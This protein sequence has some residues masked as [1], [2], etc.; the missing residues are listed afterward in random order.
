MAIL[1]AFTRTFLNETGASMHL[2]LRDGDTVR[3]LNNGFGILFPK[4]DF[5][6]DTFVGKCKG[7]VQPWVFP[8]KEGGWGIAA[9]RQDFEQS[10]AVPEQGKGHCFLLFRTDNF[11]EYEEIGL[12]PLAPEGETITDLRCINVDDGY[13]FYAQFGGEWHAYKTADLHAFTPV[14]MKSYMAPNRQPLA[15]CD[16]A[17]ACVLP[18]SD[19]MAQALR[20]R[21]TPPAL[22]ESAPR[23][24]YPLMPER[25]DPMAIRW[26][27]GYLFAATDDECGQRRLLLR[28][29][30]T[31]H[32][33]PAAKDHPIFHSPDSGDYSGC[34]WAPELHMVGGKLC[35]FFA[36]GMPHWYTVQSRVIWLEGDDPLNPAC[37]SAPRRVETP[38]GDWLTHTGI[39]LDMTVIPAK[40]G[41]HVVWS[42]RVIETENGLRCGSADLYIAKLDS[43][44][45]WKLLTEPLCLSRPEYGWERIHSEVLEGPFLLRRGEMLHLTYAA[46]LIDHTYAVGMLSAKDGDDL[47]DPV[48]WRKCNYPLLHRLSM[49]DQLGAGHNAFVK[50]DEGN[51]ILLIHALSKEN[52]L[53]D[54]TDGRRFPCFRAVVWDEYDFP[55]LDAQ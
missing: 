14:P 31:L 30:K 46:A 38:S 54:P 13:S 40:T 24:P 18:I 20:T 36:A 9:L 22:P 47:L 52:Y 45:P 39:T 23:F 26:K 35:I 44:R 41:D 55:H 19:D 3:P 5:E 11:C 8:M 43:Q 48:S 15:C 16:A 21:F 7:L 27:G 53:H 34:I 4:A 1:Y 49:P 51:D 29:A 2:A 28:W 10:K 12:I 50:D 33:I 17:P 32:E 6:A 37:W 42:Q 25:G